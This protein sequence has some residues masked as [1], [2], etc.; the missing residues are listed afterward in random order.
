MFIDRQLK[1]LENIKF[2]VYYIESNYILS[3][4]YLNLNLNILLKDLKDILLFVFISKSTK[5]LL[6]ICSY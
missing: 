6:Y 3:K 5:F 2:N 1:K 4:F